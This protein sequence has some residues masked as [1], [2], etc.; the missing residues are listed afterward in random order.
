MRV[1][2]ISI[3][4]ESNT[5]IRTPTDLAQF[6]QDMLATGAEVRDRFQHTHHEVGGFL[7]GLDEA[8][9]DAVPILAARALPSGAIQTDALAALLEMMGAG[10]DHAGRLDGL[11]VA[12]HGAAVCTAQ[13]D[14]DGHWLGLLRRRLGPQ[15]PM[16]CTLDPHANLSQ[17][18][19]E[20]CTA[21]LAYRTNPHLDQRQC[22]LEAARLLVRT[23]RGEIHPT[24]ACALPPIA[25]N[26]TS[27]AT[28]EVPCR[29]I[30]ELADDMLKRPGVL[31]NSII[32]GFPYAD[33]E[34][35]GSA[36]I[37][38]TDNDPSWAQA[39]ADELAS[40][41]LAHRSAFGSQLIEVDDAIDQA[42]Q[43]DGPVC[44]LDMGD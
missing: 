37:V 32:L 4:H 30:Y 25:I 17:R 36:F 34:E 21:T 43:A 16:V 18:M 31:S 6:R 1:G 5:F 20:A 7:K 22:G 26:I 33:V 12:P 19:I 35:M 24:Q 23:L 42:L 40:Y 29:P 44:L 8:G 11:L 10:L 15:L 2:I 39:C 41:L 13:R 3:Q 14:M 9:V 27:Q 28:D 38:V